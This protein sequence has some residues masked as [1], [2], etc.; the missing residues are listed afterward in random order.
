M[1]YHDPAAVATFAKENETV[2]GKKRDAL[3]QV[4]RFARSGRS[5]R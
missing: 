5:S 1:Q 2:E 4:S 3:S